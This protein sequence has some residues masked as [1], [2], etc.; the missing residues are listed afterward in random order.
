MLRSR[1]DY[2]KGTRKILVDLLYKKGY[3]L[4]IPDPKLIKSY[5]EQV[6]STW[7]QKFFLNK[8]ELDLAIIPMFML[9]FINNNCLT[10]EQCKC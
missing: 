4:C 1:I 7:I 9:I 2:Q 5:L 10:Y 3:C 8:N 6:R